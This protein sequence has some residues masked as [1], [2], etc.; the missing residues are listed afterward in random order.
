MALPDFADAGTVGTIIAAVITVF[1][2]HKARQILKRSWEDEPTQA[3]S[4]ELKRLSAEIK[5]ASDVRAEIKEKLRE[6]RHEMF[7]SLQ[8]EIGSLE[9]YVRSLEKRLRATE[10]D[11]ARMSGNGGRPHQR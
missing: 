6:V 4:T 5:E 7:N 10:V 3:I 1:I 9:L 2:G 8:K 11:I